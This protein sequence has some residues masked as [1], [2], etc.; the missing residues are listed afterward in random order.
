[1]AGLVFVDPVVLL[2]NLKHVL[3]NFIYSPREG[4]VVDLIGAPFI[5]SLKA[6]FVTERS[7]LGSCRAFRVQYPIL[8]VS[9]SVLSVSVAS[10]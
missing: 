8:I 7:E 9:S 2:L 10:Y 6:G 4:T 5:G 1:V 3:Y